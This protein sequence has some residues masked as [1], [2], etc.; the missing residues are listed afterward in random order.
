MINQGQELIIK[1]QIK[2]KKNKIDF[3]SL[4]Q[5][6]IDLPHKMRKIPNS[7][8]GIIFPK[9]RSMW[10][11]NKFVPKPNLGKIELYIPTKMSY[12]LDIIILRVMCIQK[13]LII[14]IQMGKEVLVL[15]NLDFKRKKKK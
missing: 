4:V 7:D 2:I 3:N 5:L 11:K 15:K 14:I 9:K 6:L 12:V 13:P 10:R 8:L 1:K